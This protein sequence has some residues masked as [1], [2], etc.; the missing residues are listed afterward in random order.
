M[1]GAIEDLALQLSRT[2]PEPLH[3]QISGM[4]R[5]RIVSGR[6]PSHMRL[7]SEP[8]LANLLGRRTWH[9]AAGDPHA[10]RR[11]SADP[12]PGPRHVRRLADAGAVVRPG[13]R[14]DGR[15]AR[16]RR[17]A[18]RDPGRT[19]RDRA[20]GRGHRC[21]P[22]A[23]RQRG[24]GRRTAP[25]PV[26]RGRPC[27]RP[28]Q[29]RRQLALPGP[30]VDGPDGTPAVLG[31]RG[32][33]RAGRQRSAAHVPGTGRGEEVAHLL[34]VPAGSPVL[35]LEQ[36]SYEHDTNPIEYSDVWIR[37]RQAAAVVLAAWVRQ[38]IGRRRTT[39][40]STQGW[41]RPWRTPTRTPRTTRS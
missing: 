27:V 8:D 28:R 6:W 5:Q 19:P 30:G 2:S 14:L 36:I 3:D 22:A 25:G 24:T 18:L 34:Q 23:L 15:G 26:R 13:D 31:A 39:C 10:D 33:V 29:L 1:A 11:G 21:P 32:G 38:A 37:R 17:G 40:T 16:P 41:P 7:P 12:A 35:Y 9:G 20:G 4:L